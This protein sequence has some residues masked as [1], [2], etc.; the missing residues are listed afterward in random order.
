M[1]RSHITSPI[2]ASWGMDRGETRKC[3]LL[4]FWHKG[5]EVLGEDGED[6][7]VAMVVAEFEFF[8]IQGE[9]DWR[10]TA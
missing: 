10:D 7:F 5:A 2:V 8:D 1:F 4:K 3:L 9:I 6:I